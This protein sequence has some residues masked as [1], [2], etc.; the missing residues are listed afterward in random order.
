MQTVIDC[1]EKVEHI[2]APLADFEASKVT[3]VRAD[4]P[5]AHLSTPLHCVVPRQSPRIRY[6]LYVSKG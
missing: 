3:I 4:V 5:V 2:P 1:S 6:V